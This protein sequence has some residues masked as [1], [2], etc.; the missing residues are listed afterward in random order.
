MAP[1]GVGVPGPGHPGIDL[2]AKGLVPNC[3]LRN[4][5]KAAQDSRALGATAGHQ[6]TVRTGAPDHST[7]G[8]TAAPAAYELLVF[9]LNFG[10]FGFE[11]RPGREGFFAL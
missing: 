4:C 9:P 10:S 5:T 1:S 3:P 6:E 7:L 2:I 11:P 8:G